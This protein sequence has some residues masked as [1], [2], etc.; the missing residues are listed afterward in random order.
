MAQSIKTQTIIWSKGSVMTVFAELGGQLIF[1]LGFSNFMLAKYQKFAYDK[2]ALKQLYYQEVNEDEDR[3]VEDGQT[4]LSTSWRENLRKRFRN[5]K[6]LMNLTYMAFLFV[7][8]LKSCCCCF[9]RG[10]ESNDNWYSRR[11]K[12]LAKFKIAQEKLNSEVDMKAI[13]KFQRISKFLHK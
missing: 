3:V 11:L 5:R 10:F 6:E 2:A 7:P 4:N 13:I 1:I 9:M 8:I 12:G